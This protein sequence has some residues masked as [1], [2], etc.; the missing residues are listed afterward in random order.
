MFAS[1]FEVGNSGGL[2]LSCPFQHSQAND[3]L[4]KSSSEVSLFQGQ[5]AHVHGHVKPQNHLQCHRELQFGVGEEIVAPAAKA[6]GSTLE[7]LGKDPAWLCVQSGF[8]PSINHYLLETRKP[9]PKK[10]KFESSGTLR[11]TITSKK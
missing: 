9:S 1:P 5:R 6:D 4:L 10:F 11:P 8:N 3:T 7:F 2:F